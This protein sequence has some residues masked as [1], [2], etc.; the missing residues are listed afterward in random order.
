MHFILASKDD[1]YSMGFV[2]SCYMHT[3]FV[4]NNELKNKKYRLR[5]I[6]AEEKP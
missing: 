3:S 5:Q 1:V 6:D 2:P 4:D